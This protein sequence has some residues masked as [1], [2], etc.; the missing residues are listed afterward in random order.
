MLVAGAVVP[1]ASAVAD[2]DRP[3]R[4]R[5]A[6]AV[7]VAPPGSAPAA[8]AGTTAGPT[9]V[10]RVPRP[11]RQHVVLPSGADLH[12]VL[13]STKLVVA[14]VDVDTGAVVAA[15]LAVTGVPVPAVVTNGLL[16]IAAGTGPLGSVG[17][18]RHA[19]G[20]LRA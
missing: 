16:R 9:G 1:A 4:G 13:R 15:A 2:D 10:P 18:A 8:A 20:H 5:P 6:A 19:Q 11:A 7:P 14:G 3:T 12:G 17:S